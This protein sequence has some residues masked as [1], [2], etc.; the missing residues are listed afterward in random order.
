M[1][2]PVAK[3]KKIRSSDQTGFHFSPRTTSHLPPEI[4][5][6]SLHHKHK[7]VQIWGEHRQSIKLM[8]KTLTFLGA[9]MPSP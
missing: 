5:E 7:Q 8:W 6:L 1:A 9:T 4:P 2:L 3:G